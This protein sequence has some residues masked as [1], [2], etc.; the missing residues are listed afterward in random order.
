[1]N[2]RTTP[3]ATATDL[4]H[5]LQDVDLNLFLVFA[6]IYE[7]GSV[8]G[9][10]EALGLTQPAVSHSL[11]RL[12]VTVDDDLFIRHKNKLLPTPFAQAIVDDVIYAL[13]VLRSRSFE[14]QRFD[15][16]RAEV[17]LQISLAVSMEIFILPRLLERLSLTA[18]KVNIIAVRQSGEELEDQLASG[19]TCLALDTGAA[20][21]TLMQTALATDQLVAVV[22][23]GNPIVKDGMSKKTYLAARHVLVNTRS[24]PGTLEDDE[25][26]RLGLR[27]DIAAQCTALTT[28][29]RTVE[30]TDYV[31]T[32]GLK[33][34]EAIHPDHDLAIFDFPFSRP[35]LSAVLLWHQNRDKDPANQWLRELIVELFAQN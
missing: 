27:R 30:N 16:L 31:V 32:L 28:A 9:A 8:T 23:K 10:A 17:T 29:L 25:L 2:P 7:L 19:S 22:R 12:R 15:P 6:T 24:N 18:P 11:A 21:T 5:T 14:P 33:Q 20:T 34:L 3:A 35:S 13:D 26:D 4:L 1:M